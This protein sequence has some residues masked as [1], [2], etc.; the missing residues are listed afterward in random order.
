[1]ALQS[2]VLSD[3]YVSEK[4]NIPTH[5]RIQLGPNKSLNQEQL[6]LAFRS[7]L[8]GRK[9]PPLVDESGKALKVTI[10]FDSRGTAQLQVGD[11][12]FA[13]SH[14]GLLSPNQEQRLKYLDGYLEEATLV[15]ARIDEIRA[16]LERP[17]KDEEFL[18]VIEIL[19]T[20][21]ESFV[22]AIK[23]KVHANNLTNSDLLPNNVMHWDNLV[24]PWAGSQ[25][26]EAFL[27]NERE[28]EST[29]LMDGSLVRAFDAT[30]LSF[31]APALVPIEKFKNIPADDIVRMLQRAASL[32]DHFAMIG[33]FEICADWFDKDHRI[34]AVGV[35]LLDELF[36][37][38]ERLEH[39]CM[40]YAAIFVMS[41]ARLA[42]HETL[43][44][45]PPFWRRITAAAQSSLVLRACEAEKGEDLFEWAM[46]HSGKAFIF[47]VLLE[48]DQEPRWKPDWLTTR[49]LVADAFGRVDSVIKKIP[50]EKQPKAWLER[51]EK[52]R[53]WISEQHSELFCILPAIGESARRKQSSDEAT[54]GFEAY[55]KKL[56]TEPNGQNLLMCAAGFYTVGV[57]SEAAQACHVVMSQLQKDA[58]GWD[59]GEVK[60][61]IQTLS[62]VAMQVQDTS[63]ANS[64]ADFCVE[65]VRELPDEGSTL[66]IL[67]RLIECASANPDHSQA[68]LALA[69]RLETVAFLAPTSMLLDLHDSLQHLQLLDD[70]LSRNLGRAMATSRLGRKAA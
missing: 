18:S 19:S 50:E 60:Y 58:S 46:Q 12:I 62:F 16:L 27:A 42:Q 23:E 52:A 54:Y 49:H 45:R 36:G 56:C 41:L 70:T 40:S 53:E 67:C 65:K 31:C 1:M 13:F 14:A 33:A 9:V 55:Y 32:P 29:R 21:Q 44:Q 51:I 30:S 26:L 64:I 63:L 15:K 34:E 28:A 10:E 59:Q 61:V 47:S 11:I 68:M 8:S 69:R 35:Q 66:E 38:R 39:R 37:S 17:A 5:R 25:T 6:L 57:T 3:G 4:Y 48:G 22:R 43:R 7:V 2:D 24:A 20:A